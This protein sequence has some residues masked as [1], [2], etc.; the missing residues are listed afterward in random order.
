MRRPFIGWRAMISIGHAVC[1]TAGSRTLTTPATQRLSEG[2]SAVLRRI[3]S[4]AMT[5]CNPSRDPN[6]LRRVGT[7]SPPHEP[8]HRT[9]PDKAKNTAVLRPRNQATCQEQLRSRTMGD[10]TC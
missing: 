8:L 6:L 3:A 4:C 2:R 10:R 7:L 5:R 1:C 9:T